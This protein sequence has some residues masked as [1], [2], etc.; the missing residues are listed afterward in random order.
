ML[1]SN[2]QTLQCIYCG[3]AYVIVRQT[4]DEAKGTE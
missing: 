1:K 4:R 3:G 2:K